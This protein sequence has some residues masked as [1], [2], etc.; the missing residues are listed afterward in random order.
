[1]VWFGQESVRG[2]VPVQRRVIERYHRLGRRAAVGWGVAG[3]AGIATAAGLYWLWVVALA[4][5]GLVAV[6]WYQRAVGW[7][8]AERMQGTT[9]VELR[10]VSDEFAAAVDDASENAPPR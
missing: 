1:M 10:R 5:V 3:I 2:Q 9:V 7:V 6:S 4:G 8:D